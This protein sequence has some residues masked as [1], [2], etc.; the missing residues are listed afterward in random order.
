MKTDYINKKEW[1]SDC[2]TQNGDYG[3]VLGSKPYTTAF[4]EAFP[5]DCGFIRGEGDNIEQAEEK[6][7]IR[8]QSIINCSG[9]EFDGRGR[10]DGYG[11]CK[12]CSLS[13]S[14]AL[15]ILNKCKV[16]NDPTNWR[17]DFKGKY[18]CKK[19]GRLA[20]KDPNESRFWR[21]DRKHPRRYKKACKKAYHNLLITKYGIKEKITYKGG[22]LVNYGY[23][24]NGKCFQFNTFSIRKTINS[25]PK[26]YL[27]LK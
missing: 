3:I 4:F 18:W 17:K 9:H 15:P 14:G 21:T 26:N 23:N 12:N 5:K 1:P 11:Y 13:K 16:C 6:A 27:K 22:A 10:T 24:S 7:W 2:F 8:Y 20:P 25:Q 19:H